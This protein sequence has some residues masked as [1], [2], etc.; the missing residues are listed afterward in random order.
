MNKENEE[1]N[2][3]IVKIK[4]SNTLIIVEGKKDKIALQKLGFGNIMELDKKPLFQVAEKVSNLT[5]ECIILTDLDKKGKQ[6]Y[7]RLSHDLQAMG[8][9]I[10]NELRNFLFKKTKL[11]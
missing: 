8:I 9:K 6:L 3:L 10:N 4:N 11:R 2:N 1:I 5:K 7:G